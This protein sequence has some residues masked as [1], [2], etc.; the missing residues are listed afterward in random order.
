MEEDRNLADAAPST[1]ASNYP[2]S[3]LESEM[4]KLKVSLETKDL[5]IQNLKRTIE[6]FQQRQGKG[7]GSPANQTAVVINIPRF[8]SNKERFIE[9]IERFIV[10]IEPKT[11][12]YGSYDQWYDDVLEKMRYQYSH[13]K[14]HLLKS[15]K[16]QVN[17]EIIFECYTS[18][19]F[20]TYRGREIHFKLKMES[21]KE[22]YTHRNTKL[23]CILHPKNPQACLELEQDRI[24]IDPEKTQI[25]GYNWLSNQTN[26]IEQYCKVETTD[27]G[28]RNCMI[29]CAIKY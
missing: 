8:I 22:G 26:D 5:E 3:G 18:R 24:I 4:K 2:N 13:P 15:Q 17:D 21:L 12:I 7:N 11:T 19:V 25:C 27:C 9:G 20:S 6:H 23:V 1:V 10:G 29:L 28:S 16:L 14:Y